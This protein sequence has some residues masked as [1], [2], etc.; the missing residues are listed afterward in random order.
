VDFNSVDFNSATDCDL[1][2]VEFGNDDSCIVNRPTSEIQCES[3]LQADHSANRFAVRTDNR[4]I[5]E[6]SCDAL[7]RLRN[8][9]LSAF[10]ELFSLHRPQL[11]RIADF[12]MDNRLRARLDTD[13]VLQQAFLDAQKRIANLQKSP[14]HSFL[15]WMRFILRQ[16]IIDFQRKHLVSARRDIGRENRFYSAFDSDQ[17][18]SILIQLVDSMTSPSQT[19]SKQE[20]I[21]RVKSSI[22]LLSE[23]EREII[24]LRHFEELSNSEIAE[25][26]QIS[27]KNAS[28]RYIRALEKLRNSLS[29]VPDFFD[30]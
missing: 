15:V 6:R 25:T 2:T 4:S 22:Q 18:V 12:R 24:A 3:S 17:S 14:T 7:G 28:I 16:T 21:E 26:L 5:E 11:F 8:G 19:I 13:D 20:L 1:H 23:N 9:D 27:Q 29:N 30:E 10:N